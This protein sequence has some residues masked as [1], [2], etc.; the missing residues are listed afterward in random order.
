MKRSHT[1]LLAGAVF[2]GFS[3]WT[4]WLAATADGRWGVLLPFVLFATAML[5]I[6]AADEATP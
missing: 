6:A 1:L 5:F 3:A 2:G 4:M